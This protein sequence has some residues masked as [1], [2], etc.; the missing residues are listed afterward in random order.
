MRCRCC[1][2]CSKMISLAVQVHVVALGASA[3][4]SMFSYCSLVTRNLSGESLFISYPAAH[5]V[6]QQIL[7]NQDIGKTFLMPPLSTEGKDGVVAHLAASYRSLVCDARQQEH[8]LK[9]FQR[10]LEARNQTDDGDDR[11]ITS[12]L[13]FGKDEEQGRMHKQTDLR[14]LRGLEDYLDRDAGSQQKSKLFVVENIGPSVATLLGA[15]F[16]IDPQ[17]F[18]DHF[19]NAPWYRL[20]DVK[21]HLPSLP[22]VH[23][24]SDYVRFRCFATRTFTPTTPV[25]AFVKD[26]LPTRESMYIR[27]KGSLNQQSMRLGVTGDLSDVPVS[28][29]PVLFTRQFV[30]VW[31]S[32]Y[33]KGRGWRGQ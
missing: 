11:T 6:A 18:A 32:K 33:V 29:E 5:N 9:P 16:A 4:R 3:L 13:E 7:S 8:D 21:D 25:E 27:R 24:A 28:F 30:T 26:I 17:M 1:G 2:Q 10:L 14:G 19:E 12:V 15:T 31:F 22:S 20:L 23:R